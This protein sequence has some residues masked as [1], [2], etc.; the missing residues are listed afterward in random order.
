M[1][2]MESHREEGRRARH[3]RIVIKEGLVGGDSASELMDREKKEDLGF[4]GA[5]S[6]VLGLLGGAGWQHRK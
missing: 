5:G 3:C 4:Q 2:G 6:P 1:V